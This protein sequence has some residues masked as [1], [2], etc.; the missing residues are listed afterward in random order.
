M[1]TVVRNASGLT[2]VRHDSAPWRLAL[3]KFFPRLLLPRHGTLGRPSSRPYFRPR[4]YDRAG[5]TGRGKRM[6]RP[7]MGL[8][9]MLAATCAVLGQENVPSTTFSKDSV[10]V[11]QAFED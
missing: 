8:A 1:T 11:A 4:R 5:W 9:V 10:N 6:R 7:L 2:E 3:P